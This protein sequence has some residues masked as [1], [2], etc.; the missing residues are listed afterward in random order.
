MV[1]YKYIARDPST[2]KKIR[3]II[4]AENEKSVNED[5]KTRNLALVEASIS[6][7][8][9]ILD[10]IRYRVKSKDKVIFSRQLTTLIDASLPLV[11]SLRSVLNQTKNKTLQ[12]VVTEVINDVEGGKAFSAAL[13][14][15][16]NV[17]NPVFVSLVAAGEAS[18]TL[19]VAM[20]RI[21]YQQEKDAELVS[22][23]RGAMI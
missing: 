1:M 11:Q 4:N 3:G 10:K 7:G 18:G 16:P 2:G 21:A 5:V 13:A 6:S 8:N 15:H 14:K 22:K 19:D 20:E 9:N 23:V 17:F 12:A